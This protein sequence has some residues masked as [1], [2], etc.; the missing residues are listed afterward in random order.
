MKL[1]CAVY[2]LFI[3]SHP[4]ITQVDKQFNCMGRRKKNNFKARSDNTSEIAAYHTIGSISE[5]IP[6]KEDFYMY[7]KRLEVWM[8][9][10]KISNDDKGSVFLSLVGPTVFELITNMCTPDDP[11]TKSY[12]DLIKIADHYR[13]ARNPVTE[14][15]VFRERKQKSGESIG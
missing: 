13:K 1:R 5:Y 4:P 12:D 6:D 14:R 7:R 2:Q 15:V 3:S 11:V 9:V 8:R 10:N